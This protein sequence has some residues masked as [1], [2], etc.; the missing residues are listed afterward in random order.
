MKG[1]IQ[2]A[3]KAL[4]KC[5][6]AHR[7]QFYDYSG[8]EDQ[9]VCIQGESVPIVADVRSICQAVFGRDDIVEVGW[10]FT[11]VYLDQ[12]LPLEEVD[13][14]TLRMALPYGTEL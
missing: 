11:T 10:G 6:E 12:C 8:Q 9:Q 5:A 7:S 4:R 13:E 3:V 1:T 2:L 14:T